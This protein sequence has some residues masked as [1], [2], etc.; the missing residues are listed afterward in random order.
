MALRQHIHLAAM[1]FYGTGKKMQK[2]LATLKAM[3][4]IERAN[5][6]SFL[7]IAPLASK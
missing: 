2:M 3:A 5:H 7:H 6:R 1:P 4:R